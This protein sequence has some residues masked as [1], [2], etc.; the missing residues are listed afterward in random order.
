MVFSVDKEPSS[1]TARYPFN[2][3]PPVAVKK[4]ADFFIRVK[5]SKIISRTLE[6]F[7]P[8]CGHNRRLPCGKS[9][10]EFSRVRSQH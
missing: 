2:D 1:Q 7:T 5:K 9:G 8:D 4:Q 10:G 6:H 3:A